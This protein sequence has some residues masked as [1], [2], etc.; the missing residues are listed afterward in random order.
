MRRH[1]F[2]LFT[3]IECGFTLKMEFVLR[4]YLLILSTVALLTDC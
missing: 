4:V 3:A 1:T 2:Y